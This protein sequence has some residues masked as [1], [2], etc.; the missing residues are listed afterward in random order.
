MFHS[1]VK[2][3]SERKDAKNTYFSAT[4][5]R[6][7]IYDAMKKMKEWKKKVPKK[8]ERVTAYIFMAS[9]GVIQNES[10]SQKKQRENPNQNMNYSE[11]FLSGGSPS[12]CLKNPP[13]W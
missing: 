13:L 10:D 11:P 7:H 1:K 12:Q 6:M 8:A 4:F 3:A 9:R 5:R 2:H